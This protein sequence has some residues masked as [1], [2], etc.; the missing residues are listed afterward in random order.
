MG[1]IPLSIAAN[2]AAVAIAEATESEEPADE[3]GGGE[4]KRAEDE[5]TGGGGTELPP[6]L[7]LLRLEGAEE[8][9]ISNRRDTF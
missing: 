2:C 3:R 7:A 9:N 4:S 1:F 5:G 6:L 8:V